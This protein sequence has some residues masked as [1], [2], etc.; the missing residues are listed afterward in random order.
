MNV[1]LSEKSH[2][3]VILKYSLNTN[4]VGR[5]KPALPPLLFFLFS[6]SFLTVLLFWGHIPIKMYHQICNL[7]TS[8]CVYATNWIYTQVH[9]FHFSFT[10]QEIFFSNLTLLC[11]IFTWFQNQVFKTYSMNSSYYHLPFISIHSSPLITSL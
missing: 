10:F 2:L 1:T 3:Q 4:S 9:L 11:K 7:V 8:L 5:T 6:F